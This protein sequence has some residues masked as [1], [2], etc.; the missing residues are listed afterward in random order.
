MLQFKL[1]FL[2]SLKLRI[3]PQLHHHRQVH[4][5]QEAHR[6]HQQAYRYKIL[7]AAVGV[8]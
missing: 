8:P 6:S 7:K 5:K 3:H 1:R 4:H 2:R